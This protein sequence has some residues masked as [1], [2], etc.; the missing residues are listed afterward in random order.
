[1]DLAGLLLATGNGLPDLRRWDL[2]SPPLHPLRITVVA[3]LFPSTQPHQCP[4]WP[5]W[6]RHR[7]PRHK[8]SAA[9]LRGSAGLLQPEAATSPPDPHRS[10]S[11]WWADCITSKPQ[12]AGALCSSPT[13]VHG[14]GHYQAVGADSAASST[15]AV[16]W[17]RPR[18]IASICVPADFSYSAN[19]SAASSFSPRVSISRPPCWSSLPTSEVVS[20]LSSI[21][22]HQLAWHPARWNKTQH[23]W[24]GPPPP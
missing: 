19:L 22:L 18:P 6:S 14:V 20:A 3:S 23:A 4:L 2:S 9:T 21:G 16:I 5:R 13:S 11:T 12:I 24:Q 8:A 17:P 7:G 1:M 15:T 10:R